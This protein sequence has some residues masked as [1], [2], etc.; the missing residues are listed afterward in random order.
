[1]WTVAFSCFAC[2]DE[3]GYWFY[4][5][6]SLAWSYGLM[7]LW[8]KI[9]VD[10]SDHLE[11]S[12]VKKISGGFLIFQRKLPKFSKFSLCICLGGVLKLKLNLYLIFW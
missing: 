6:I 4:D 1:M 9:V 8:L 3:Y 10:F 12:C 5:C 7:F 11:M 2:V